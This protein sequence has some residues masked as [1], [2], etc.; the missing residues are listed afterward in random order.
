MS[1]LRFL[2]LWKDAALVLTDSGG[3]QEETTTLGIPCFTIRDNTER[4]ITIDEGTNILAGTTKERIIEEYKKFMA[5]GRKNGRVPELWDGKAAER[6]VDVL[7][8][9][10][11][12]SKIERIT[13]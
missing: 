11:S 5:G 2:S 9:H 4:P 10:L 12:D 6:I 13:S 7:S 1:Y 8:S 3:L